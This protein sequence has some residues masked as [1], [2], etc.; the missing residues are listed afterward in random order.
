MSERDL[1][2]LVRAYLA[3]LDERN[4]EACLAYFTDDAEIDFQD[5]RFVGLEGVREWHEE[6]FL[7]DLRLTE[8]EDMRLEAD[9]KV[10]V[11][12][13]VTSNTLRAWRIDNLTGTVTFSFRGEKIR[14]ASFGLRLYNEGLW[15]V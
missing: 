2:G 10:V 14:A 7:A 12:A 11:D 9:D 4:L 15:H 13:V 5:G 6:R 8:I 3:V 1:V